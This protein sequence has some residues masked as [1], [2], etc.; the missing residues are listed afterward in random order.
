[1][2]DGVVAFDMERYPAVPRRL[3]RTAADVIR[4]AARLDGLADATATGGVATL[5]A[6]AVWLSDEA[7][8]AAHRVG[9]LSSIPFLDHLGGYSR[10]AGGFAVE[11][12]WFPGDH[13]GLQSFE[14]V[15]ALSLWARGRHLVWDVQD[16]RTP[17][18]ADVDAF[19]VALRRVGDADSAAHLLD[20]FGADGAR[21]LLT[22]LA[23]TATDGDDPDEVARYQDGLAMMCGVAGLAAVA[24]RPARPTVPAG[25]EMTD[26]VQ[27]WVGA[28]GTASDVVG[29]AGGAAGLRASSLA[30]G[31]DHLLAAAGLV[32][33]LVDAGQ[34]GLFAEQTVENAA[35]T[36]LSG[37]G[38]AAGGFTG[39]VIGLGALV[40]WA[41]LSSEPGRP[42]ARTW[43]TD[44]DNPG[45]QHWLTTVNGAGVPVAPN[46][47]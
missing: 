23:M 30:R 46:G 35:V 4:M 15:L 6:M 45:G 2:L 9:V 38:S 16:G 32:S 27:T 10:A 41:I 17:E 40:L 43:P 36:V 24:V 44:Q 20:L 11:T 14:Q 37:I 12:D 28:A 21:D 1:M 31:V 34:H 26:A 39:A 47:S 18:R 13:D 8:R 25:D 42:P 5:Q 22:A 19:F 7:T 29:H 3:D 33:V